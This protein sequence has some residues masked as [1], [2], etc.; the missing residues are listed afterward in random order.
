MLNVMNRVML[1]G[2]ASLTITTSAFV[3]YGKKYDLL[4]KVELE[5]LPGALSGR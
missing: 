4:K 1:A 5:S 3:M 2:V